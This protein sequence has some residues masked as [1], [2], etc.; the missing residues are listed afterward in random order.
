MQG[1]VFIALI[2][3][4]CADVVVDNGDLVTDFTFDLLVNFQTLFVELKSFLIVCLVVVDS[5]NAT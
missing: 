5:S 3:V 2:F 1:F 4:D